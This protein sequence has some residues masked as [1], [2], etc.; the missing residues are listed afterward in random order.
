MIKVS[1]EAD[2]NISASGD[3]VVIAAVTGRKLV[4]WKI[5]LEA[6]G[7]A[8]IIFKDG[9]GGTAFNARALVLDAHGTM[10]LQQDEMINWR[11]SKGNAFVINSSTTGP[12][13][14]RVHYTL[15]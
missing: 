15:L 7:A 14:G 1:R 11:T 6:I 3:N 4:I 12:I 13:T 9:V 2:I 10:V 8:D 5:W